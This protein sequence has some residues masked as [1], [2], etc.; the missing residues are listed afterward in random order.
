MADAARLRL[1]FL[2]PF[3]PRLQATHGGAKAIANLIST[4]AGRHDV[5]LLSLRADYEPPVDETIRRACAHVSEVR[6][7]TNAGS[8]A[9]RTKHAFRLATAPFRD[10]PVWAEAFDVSQFHEEA[11]RI[12]ASWSPDLVQIDFH[13]MGQYMQ[14]LQPLHAPIV[15][16]QHEPG[17]STAEERLRRVPALLRWW[18]RREMQAWRQFESSVF[19]AADAVVVF[20]ES[21]AEAVSDIAP[22]ALIRRIP[23]AIRVEAQ[24]AEERSDDATLLFVANFGHPPNMDAARRLID[25]ILPGVRRLVPNARLNLIGQN[26]RPAWKRLE[27]AGITYVDFAPDLAPHF[28]RASVLVAPL[29]TGGGMRVKTLEAL[30]AGKPLVA[31]PLA[32]RGLEVEDGRELCLAEDDDGFVARIAALLNDPDERRRLSVNARNWAATHVDLERSASLYE[33]LYGELL[34]GT[35]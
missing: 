18:H 15:V 13:V 32:A 22:S 24:S 35:K 5:A 10:R 19:E 34:G 28:E 20:T 4:L 8:L 31:T 3:P 6:R 26:G 23:V 2:T 7:P 14:D 16:V 9:H 30:A 17:T 11:H 27:G 29:Y 12:A 25:R 21:D 33:Q 1:L